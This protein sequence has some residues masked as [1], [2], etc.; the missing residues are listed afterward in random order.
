[1]LNLRTK[2]VWLTLV[3]GSR[4]SDHSRAMITRMQQAQQAGRLVTVI[5]MVD[6]LY[7]LCQR[8]ERAE[9]L[10]ETS[11]ILYEMD[12]PLKASEL[13]DKARK[14]YIGKDHEQAVVAWMMG[15]VLLGIPS[16]REEVMTSWIRAI[17][18]FQRIADSRNHPAKRNNPT[19]HQDMIPLMEEALHDVIDNEVI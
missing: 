1:M 14:G 5:S 13:L 3:D 17:N 10:A 7:N 16:R 12:D 8:E 2:L 11:I 15:I 18:I 9:A 19:W 6:R 4:I